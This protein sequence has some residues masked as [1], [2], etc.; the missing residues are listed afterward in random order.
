MQGGFEWF[1][2]DRQSLNGLLLRGRASCPQGKF[3][4]FL[5]DWESLNGFGEL[6]G[7]RRI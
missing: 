1:L 7:T 6:L 3:E 4:W 5:D 2:D